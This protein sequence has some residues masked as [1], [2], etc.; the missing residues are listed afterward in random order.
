MALKR[1][2]TWSKNSPACGPL[3]SSPPAVALQNILHLPFFNPSAPLNTYSVFDH[4]LSTCIRD[5]RFAKSDLRHRCYFGRN[6]IGVGGRW[7]RRASAPYRRKELEARLPSHRL[8]ENST[9][10]QVTAVFALIHQTS[11]LSLTCT[12]SRGRQERKR[13]KISTDC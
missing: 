13:K 2:P 3:P 5:A 8:K 10:A 4:H 7:K 9:A 6:L 11:L 1:S 12:I